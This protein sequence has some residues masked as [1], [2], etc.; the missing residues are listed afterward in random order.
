[1]LFWVHEKLTRGGQNE[2]EI[3]PPSRADF[4]QRRSGSTKLNL[5]DIFN[6]MWVRLS[7]IH[8]SSIPENA[9]LPYQGIPTPNFPSH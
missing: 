9:H 4:S 5:M 8:I 3:G 1:M 7:C 2:N 6:N